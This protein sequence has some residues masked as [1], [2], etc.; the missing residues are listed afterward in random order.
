[1]TKRCWY[2]CPVVWPIWIDDLISF[3]FVLKPAFHPVLAC[4]AL[5][6]GQEV[7]RFCVDLGDLLF[8]YQLRTGEAMVLAETRLHERN[9]EAESPFVYH[10]CLLPLNAVHF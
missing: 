10:E 5:L 7:D 2:R 4:V 8:L 9:Q 3:P 1:M 6:R